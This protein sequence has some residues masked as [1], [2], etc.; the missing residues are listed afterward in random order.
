VPRHRLPDDLAGPGV[1]RGVQQKR[2]VP[3]VLKAAPLGAARRQGQHRI[4]AIE[5]LNGRPLVG[6]KDDGVL[7]R[8]EIQAQDE[9]GIRAPS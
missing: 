5:G 1:E 8:L 3:V 6:R 7:R 2:A 9:L 4:Q